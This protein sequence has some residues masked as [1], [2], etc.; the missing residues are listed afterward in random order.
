MTN[1][2]PANVMVQIVEL[3]TPLASEERKRVVSAAMTLLGE[4]SIMQ[5]TSNVSSI[6]SEDANDGQILLPRT[7]TWLKQSNLAASDLEEVFHFGKDGVE[8]IAADV[9]G[10]NSKE[11]TYNAYLL[12]GISKFLVTGEATF[13]DKS[14]RELCKTI[15]CYN[16]GNHASYLKDK[17]N[18]LTGSKE[19]GWALT[20]PGLKQAA[21]LITTL[22]QG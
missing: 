18:G 5:A 7:K 14:A 13:D 20:S 2:S 15:G 21:G 3:L 22:S 6:E 17:K 8:F 19:K 4:T 11:K 9:P 10:N 12:T 16:E 1:T